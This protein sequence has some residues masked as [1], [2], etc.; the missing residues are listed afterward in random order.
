[1]RFVFT[2]RAMDDLRALDRQVQ[3][4]L[5]RK[6]A[7]YFAKPQPLKFSEPL[8]RVGAHRLRIGD[9]RVIFDLERGRAVIHRIGHRKDI[10]R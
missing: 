7:F 4:R 5:L 6:I 2:A 3:R 10:Y 1:M 8:T 9:Y